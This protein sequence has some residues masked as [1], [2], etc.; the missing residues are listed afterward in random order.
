MYDDV[1]NNNDITWTTV[2][3]TYQQTIVPAREFDV[4]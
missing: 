2:D 3:V 4:K 1:Y